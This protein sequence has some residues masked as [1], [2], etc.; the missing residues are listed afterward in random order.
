MWTQDFGAGEAPTLISEQLRFRLL[1]SGGWTT[2]DMGNDGTDNYSATV[3]LGG[4]GVMGIEYYLSA[5]DSRQQTHRAPC[6]APAETFA[7]IFPEYMSG[8]DPGIYE[9]VQ[10]SAS[11]L[12][13]NRVIEWPQVNGVRW[14]EVHYG[15]A[16]ELKH[17]SSTLIARQAP[18][19]PRYLISENQINPINLENVHVFAVR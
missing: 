7:A 12:Q 15:S 16:P 5:T 19:C 8:P 3:S 2:V 14:Y 9:E 10:F 18:C 13:G 4:Q 6:D 17:H 1:P 11:D